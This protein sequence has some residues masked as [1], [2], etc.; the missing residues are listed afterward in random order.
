[1]SREPAVVKGAVVGLLAA[2][3]HVLVVVF[4]VTLP[5]FLDEATLAGA[6][7]FVAGA[8][9]VWLIRRSVTPVADPRDE[10][11]RPLVV[12]GRAER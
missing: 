1:M 8:I 7:D 6:L 5:G 2:I 12:Q 3:V 4:N 9:V 11:G 10:H